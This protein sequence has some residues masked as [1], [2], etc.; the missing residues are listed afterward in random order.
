MSKHI[1]PKEQANR[2]R[3]YIETKKDEDIYTSLNELSSED[4]LETL[5]NL[6]SREC[7][8][9]FKFIEKNKQATVFGDLSFI[10]QSYIIRVLSTN[11]SAKLLKNLPTDELHRFLQK[12][13]RT[14]RLKLLSI[15]DSVDP[16]LREEWKRYS[17]DEVGHWMSSDFFTVDEDMSVEDVL[18]KLRLR[19]RDAT[20]PL[21]SIMVVDSD[22][23]LLDKLNLDE[24]V[25]K[26]PTTL[27]KEIMDRQV[28]YLCVDDSVE[29]SIERFFSRDTI[30]MPIVDRDRVLKGVISADDVMHLAQ[31]EITEDMMK[32][33][34]LEASS[35]PYLQASIFEQFKKRGGWLLILFIGEMFTATAMGFYEEEIS[36]A[37][38]LALFLP[39][40]LS[41]GGNS[42]SQSSTL[43]IRALAL[44]EFGLGEW[45]KV[46]RREIVVGLMLGLLLGSVA[47]TRIALWEYLGWAD[48][49][50][51]GHFALFDITLAVS[52][53]IVGIVAWG[54][55]VGSLLPIGLRALRL[56]PA[57]ISA[58]FLATFVD[59]TGLIIYFSAAKIIL[60]I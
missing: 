59:V 44:K 1:E 57:T 30:V 39:L 50:E 26:A 3:S 36:H 56:D 48:Y 25:S 6:N 55:L 32:M 27:I 7:A 46:F 28:A 2:L 4:I 51:S 8:Y 54:N 15:L 14:K 31:D 52:I 40:I 16:S 12:V 42:G 43:V 49:T 47:L 34:G 17:K 9:A 20:H 24:V 33:G 41:S 22:G 35:E 11:E 29:L 18:E 19:D 38:V 58:P 23:V 53:G 5:E 21:Y 60:G 37:V 10:H 45:Y 13:P